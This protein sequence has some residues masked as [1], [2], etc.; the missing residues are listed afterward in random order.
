[1]VRVF[2]SAGRAAGVRPQDLV[3]ALV[4]GAGVDPQALGAIH[5]SDRFSVVEIRDESV[6]AAIAGLRATPLRGMEVKA[7]RDRGARPAART[8]ARSAERTP[9][10]RA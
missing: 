4:K 8:S 3:G 10:R 6:D 7:S 1:M 5:I 2:V 9:K